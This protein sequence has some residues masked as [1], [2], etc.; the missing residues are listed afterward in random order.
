MNT[1]RGKS[2][3][4][5][6]D[7]GFLIHFAPL[8]AKIKANPTKQLGE[9]RNPQRLG[10]RQ[11]QHRDHQTDG[12]GGHRE[13]PGGNG[14]AKPQAAETA[15]KTSQHGL[16]PVALSKNNSP[17]RIKMLLLWRYQ[18]KIVIYIAGRH[19]AKRKRREK[20]WPQGGFLLF[21]G[22]FLKRCCFPFSFFFFSSLKEGNCKRNCRRQLKI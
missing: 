7:P 21:C 4:A 9:K 2:L 11:Q 1:C 13:Q 10:S 8:A 6:W 20:E 12:G 19:H 5:S 15:L 17:N 16:R 3:F 14:Q 18:V 22:S